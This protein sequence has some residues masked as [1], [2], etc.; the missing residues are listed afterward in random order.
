M[1][2]N[3][4]LSMDDEST[5]MDKLHREAVNAARTIMN[6]IIDDF[7][8]LTGSGVALF[9]DFKK[10]VEKQISKK[11]EKYVQ[12]ENLVSREEYEVLLCLVQKQISEQK[13]IIKKINT[14]EKQLNLDK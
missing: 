9:V 2:S 10:D 7:A 14:L 1:E 5:K 12:K 8:K 13:D 11:I 6:S 3:Q 4:L